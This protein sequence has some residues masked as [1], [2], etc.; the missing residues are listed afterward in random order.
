MSSNAM[1][2]ALIFMTLCA[3]AGF[4]LLQ[5]LSFLQRRSNRVAANDALI[6]TT[7]RGSVPD[8][9]LPELLSVAAIAVVAMGLLTFGYTG[10]NRA[11]TAAVPLSGTVG[12]AASPDQQMSAP[13][14]PR[15]NPAEKSN[16]PTSSTSPR[17]GGQ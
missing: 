9:A 2:P 5:F 4:G 14:Q 16:V 1:I 17:P 6:G 10:S 11:Q 13:S 3:G 12:S 7:S 15:A 8:G